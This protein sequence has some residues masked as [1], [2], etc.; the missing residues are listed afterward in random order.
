MGIPHQ[1]LGNQLQTSRYG[2]LLLLIEVSKSDQYKTT[3]Y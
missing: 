1:G 2:Y 3:S